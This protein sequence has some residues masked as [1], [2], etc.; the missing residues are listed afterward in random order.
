MLKLALDITNKRQDQRVDLEYKVNQY[1]ELKSMLV[2]LQE[3][4]ASRMQSLP[5]TKHS[6]LSHLDQVPI[7]HEKISLMGLAKHGGRMVYLVLQKGDLCQK[8]ISLVTPQ[9][10][11]LTFN[12]TWLASKRRS[13]VKLREVAQCSFQRLK[14]AR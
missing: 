14:E 3:K 11:E 9:V 12:L 4:I 5:K 8:E 1:H 13:L 2:F 7:R 6:I 10:Q